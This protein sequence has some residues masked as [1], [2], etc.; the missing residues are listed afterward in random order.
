MGVSYATLK[1]A[2]NILLKQKI[3]LGRYMI[4]VQK[5]YKMN[6]KLSNTTIASGMSWDIEMCPVFKSTEPLWKYLILNVRN[7]YGIIAWSRNSSIS[8]HWYHVVSAWS[9]L[10]AT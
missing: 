2:M 1:Y 4:Y 3:N 7:L 9:R 6:L 8:E 10:G 5:M